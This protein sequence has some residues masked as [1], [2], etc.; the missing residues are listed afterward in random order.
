MDTLFV[1]LLITKITCQGAAIHCA[2]GF[3][4]SQFSPPVERKVCAEMIKSMPNQII[5]RCIPLP[6]TKKK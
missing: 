2:D 5:V 4:S 1:L 6:P 3:T